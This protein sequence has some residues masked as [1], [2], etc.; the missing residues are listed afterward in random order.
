MKERINKALQRYPKAIRALQAACSYWE[1]PQ[2]CEYLVQKLNT[3]SPYGP[4]NKRLVTTYKAM[5]PKIRAA[6][7]LDIKASDDGDRKL[8]DLV[9]QVVSLYRGVMV[10][11]YLPNH[12]PSKRTARM[13]HAG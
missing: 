8:S 3:Y 13:P 11:D 7:G 6:I 4:L 2:G 5:T 12:Q 9:K 1:K 10:N